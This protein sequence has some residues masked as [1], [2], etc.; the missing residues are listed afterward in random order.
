MVANH[1]KYIAGYLPV[2]IQSAGAPPKIVSLTPAVKVSVKEEN[3]W[4]K[5]NYLGTKIER[6]FAVISSPGFSGPHKED[7]S[8]LDQYIREV[9]LD[10]VGVGSSPNVRKYQAKVGQLQQSGVYTVVVHA[11]NMDG[12]ALPVQTTITVSEPVLS[13]DING[14]NSV[15][16]FDFVS[17]A[18]IF[19]WMGQGLNTD[20]TTVV[21]RL[22]RNLN[23]SLQALQPML[24]I[25]L[26]RV[27]LDTKKALTM[28][29]K[30]AK[31]ESRLLSDFTNWFRI[32][33]F[34][35]H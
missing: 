9:D 24:V 7:W 17:V 21:V 4:S 30:T 27:W 26:T 14:D 16:I 32:V 34:E 2:D 19:G 29:L 6:V 8:E 15:N 20:R 11:E 18:S 3:P 12:M 28:S 35:I 5:P 33:V 31:S 25:S 10:F 22:G 23:T 13:G 1:R